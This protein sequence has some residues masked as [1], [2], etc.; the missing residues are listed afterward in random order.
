[1]DWMEVFVGEIWKGGMAAKPEPRRA[2]TAAPD[3]W[4]RGKQEATSAAGRS[5]GGFL[6]WFVQPP[7]RFVFPTESHVSVSTDEDNACLSLGSDICMTLHQIE[8]TVRVSLATLICSKLALC[9]GCACALKRVLKPVCSSAEV[10]W[11]VEFAYKSAV[12]I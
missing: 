11:L 10:R 12:R 4:A 7:T 1:M 6:L 5:R 3:L 8:G 2:H 9:E